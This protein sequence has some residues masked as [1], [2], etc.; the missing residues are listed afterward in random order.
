MD[1]KIDDDFFEFS[2]RSRIRLSVASKSN[3]PNVK[4]H[5]NKK[6]KKD[7]GKKN[8]KQMRDW[9]V[10]GGISSKK[11][12]IADIAALNVGPSVE[13]SDNDCKDNDNNKFNPNGDSSERDVN[14]QLS[15]SDESNDGIENNNFGIDNN[16]KNDSGNWIWS[17]FRH[18]ISDK[19]L[20]MNDLESSL[21]DLEKLLTEKN[22]S[23]MIAREICQSVSKQ[24]IGK[25]IG[26]FD[27]IYKLVRK[28]ITESL[29]N[30]LNEQKNRQDST[31]FE[32]ILS[33]IHDARINKRPYS[34]IFVGVNGVGKSTSLAKV[35]NYLQSRNLQVSVAACDTFRSGAIEQLKT[36]CRALNARLYEQGYARDAASV[37]YNA[38]LEAKNVY[39]DDV[40]LIDTAG[41][42]QNNEKLMKSLVNLI[43]K[44]K[45]DVILFVG[46]ALV[47]NDG[48]SQLNEFNKALLNYSSN[49]S[50]NGIVLTKFDT[51][52]DKVGAAISMTYT[53]GKPIVFIGT[54]QTYSDLKRM[55]IKTIV[56]KLLK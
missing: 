37:A 30:I 17:R 8:K 5:K 21:K 24:L 36:H 3:K 54:G 1:N 27:S 26:A 47:G 13:K 35:I 25:K 51:V 34:I 53:S 20:C 42:M 31:S 15:D 33:G 28:S 9:S 16:S 43:N 56:N 48:I 14:L 52:D 23:N 50:I 40:I 38:I 4:N 12:T 29:E 6:K 55:H 11:L 46:E 45:P 2:K 41:R 10:S 22:V 32:S 39:H 49:Y 7:N 18:L 44:S 19:A